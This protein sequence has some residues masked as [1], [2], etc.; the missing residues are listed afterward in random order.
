MVAFF[1]FLLL[2]FF[3]SFLFSS[4][5]FILLFLYYCRRYCC[6]CN[7]PTYILRDVLIR[8]YGIYIYLF[9][10]FII[11]YR[12]TAIQM[13][14]GRVRTSFHTAVQP[15]ATSPKP[16]RPSRES[17]KPAVSLHHLRQGFRY[18]VKSAHP[19]G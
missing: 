13:P 11:V 4:N 17:Q 6:C 12:R 1:F 15:A 7:V 8:S 5:T 19:H 14:F 3:Y 16:R 9:I 2:L 10:G 18:R